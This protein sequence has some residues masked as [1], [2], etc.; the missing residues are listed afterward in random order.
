MSGSSA[1]AFS[2]AAFSLVDPESPGRSKFG[3]TIPGLNTLSQDM[4]QSSSGHPRVALKALSAYDLLYSPG[5]IWAD[6]TSCII[7]LSVE[8]RLLRK[9]PL[10]RR[11]EGFGK[12]SF[13]AMLE[14]FYDCKHFT[15]P[16]SDAVLKS[17]RVSDVDPNAP[18]MVLPHCDLVLTFDLSVPSVKDF[19][20]SLGFYINSVFRKFLLKYQ[21]ELVIKP[22]D[23]PVFLSEDG[24]LSFGSV[25]RL[26]RRS[27]RISILIDNYNAPSI[28]SDNSPEVNSCLN[29]MIIS[30]L[31]ESL[32]YVQGLITGIGDVPDPLINPYLRGDCDIWTAVAVDMTDE[33]VVD[34]TFGFTPEEVHELERHLQVHSVEVGLVPY[35]FGNQKVYS[36]THVLNKISQQLGGS[37]VD[38][39]VTV[40]LGGQAKDS[41]GSEGSSS[42]TLF[43]T[44]PTSPSSF[45]T[46][47]GS[48]YSEDSCG[49][50]SPIKISQG[51]FKT[52]C[53][54]STL[55]SG[56]LTAYQDILSSPGV[57]FVDRMPYLLG[58]HKRRN[59]DPGFVLVRRPAGFGKTSFLAM[60]EFFHDVKHRDSPASRSALLSTWIGDFCAPNI[61]TINLHADL[62]L[63]FDLAATRI[64]DSETS[65]VEHVNSLEK[66][67]VQVPTGAANPTGEYPP[68]ISTKMGFT[69]WLEF[70]IF[71]EQFLVGP[72]TGYLHDLRSGLIMGPGDEPDPRISMYHS[73]P[74]LWESIAS[75]LTDHEMMEGAF[76]FTAEEVHEVAREFKV[77]SVEFGLEAR[78][79]ESD[80][81]TVYSM[82]EVLEEIG[83][84]CRERGTVDTE[85]L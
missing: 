34:A 45:A 43:S 46:C 71:L 13:L 35:R 54:E 49:I 76:G 82:E 67:S 44:S 1:H 81:E 8:S 53:N 60:A 33:D 22:E 63:A 18:P 36:T 64:N 68:L 12:T 56:S 50:P 47:A 74:N 7:D 73:H 72:L 15:T 21:Q 79:F 77:Q 17:T 55:P 11:P 37:D 48:K 20:Q 30:P 80:L 3:D 27:R 6:K 9:L 83:R 28:A 52:D 38:L 16:I 69:R 40:P 29:E 70:W 23:I 85:V 14:F 58:L 57:V 62:V 61:H 10:V 84:Q 78:Y 41:D 32:S 19:P 31:T 26:A 59:F 25:L 66:I 4:L 5:V 2:V 42:D 24:M 51:I 39:D 65:L 75:D